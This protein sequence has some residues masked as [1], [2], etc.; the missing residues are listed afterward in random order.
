MSDVAQ[1]VA[2]TVADLFGGP[3][4][5]EPQGPNS[6]AA[7]PEAQDAAPEVD[8]PELTS[9]LP[10]DL[11]EFLDEPDFDDEPAVSLS[12]D[13]FVDPEELARENAKLRKRLEWTE[14]QKAKV[15]MTKWREEAEKF[16]PYAHLDSINAT[17]RRGFLR[18]ARAQHEANKSLIAPHVEALKAKEDALR[19][20][21]E[22]KVKAELAEAWGKP[23]LGG[24]PSGAPIEAAAASDDL[25]RA[26]NSRNLASIAKVLM[27]NNRI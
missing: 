19:A 27:Q 18:E 22:Q 16:F 17:S 6:P 9:S 20:E 24:G 7:A 10:D 12:E 26:R 8:L 1:A 14:A 21:I 25:E 2:G 11:A 3:A 23:N 4:E 15:E 5:A 13:E